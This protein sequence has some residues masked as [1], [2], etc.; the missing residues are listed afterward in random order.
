MFAIASFFYFFDNLGLSS[1][2]IV[3][4]RVV[5]CNFVG[6]PLTLV[7][8]CGDLMIW[9]RVAPIHSSQTVFSL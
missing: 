5:F 7:Y 1:G 2:Q 4:G 3:S 6:R 8:P 9:N